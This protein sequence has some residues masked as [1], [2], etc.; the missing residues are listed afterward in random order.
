MNFTSSKDANDEQV[1]HSKSDNINVMTYDSAN[2]VIDKNFE[3]LL[4]RY[5]IGLEASMM[6]S[7]FIFWC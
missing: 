7:D 3:S 6:G 5:Q 2:E 4:S 1:M